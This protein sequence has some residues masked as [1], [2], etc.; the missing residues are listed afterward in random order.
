MFP[1]FPQFHQLSGLE[2]RIRAIEEDNK[3]N[4]WIGLQEHGPF[5]W[6]ATNGEVDFIKGI[7]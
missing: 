4:L 1:G 3:E 7:S 5:K 6:D 2:S